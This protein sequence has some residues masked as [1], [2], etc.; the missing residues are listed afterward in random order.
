MT[1]TAVIWDERYT[2]HEMGRYHV[3][4]PDRLWAVKD[5]LNGDGVGKEVQRIEPR[6]ARVEELEFIHDSSYI[7]RV[8]STSGKDAVALDPDTSTCPYTWETALLAAGGAIVGSEQV[9]ERKI[10]N[11]FAFVRP[12]GHHAER[13]RA[14]GFCIF[15]NVAIAA[16]SMIRKGMAKS[17]AIIDI[18][19]HHGNGTQKA[20]YQREDVFFASIHRSPFYPG[21]GPREERGAGRGL[22]TTLNVPL[23]VGSDD[24]DYKFAF[25]KIIIP[26]V[27]S[28]KPEMLMVSVGFDGHILDPLG[29]MRVTTDGYRW[30]ARELCSMA[31]DLCEGRLFMILEG[32]YDLTALRESS[33]VMLEELVLASS[34]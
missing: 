29:G 27:R 1:G 11:A 18:D 24:D 14:M 30:M 34:F 7:K 15:N 21:S 9:H 19:V 16:D 32:G 28:F 5:V 13:A 12:P 23:D 26:A 20:F 10:S 4:S 17:V 8:E 31:K 25:D 6:L 33:E 3:E 22:G 2:R